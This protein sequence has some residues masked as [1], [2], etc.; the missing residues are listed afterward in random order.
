MFPPLA[1]VCSIN[2]LML[3]LCKRVIFLCNLPITS[4]ESLFELIVIPNSSEVLDNK[5]EMASSLSS[6]RLLMHKFKCLNQRFLVVTHSLISSPSSFFLVIYSIL[7]SCGTASSGFLEAFNF[8]FFSTIA[9][10]FFS[11]ISSSNM[12]Y[13][14][15]IRL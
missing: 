8:L 7:S 15:Q 5:F 1:V 14:E 10:F 3:F 4:S 2:K 9:S 6:S 11:S 12:I 13:S